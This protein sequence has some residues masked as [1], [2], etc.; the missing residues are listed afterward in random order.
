MK[1]QG[2]LSCEWCCRIMLG[3][4]KCLRGPSTCCPVITGVGFFGCV[5]CAGHSEGWRAVLQVIMD[6]SQ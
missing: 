3:G 5:A 2:L 4:G 6:L 1:V